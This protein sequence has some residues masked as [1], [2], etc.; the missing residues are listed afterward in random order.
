MEQ[1]RTLSNRLTTKYLLIVRNEEN[2]AEKST[3]SFTYSK[4]I[5][6]LV[7]SFFAFFGLS[8]YL[9]TSL[10]EAW[11]DPRFAELKAT[12]EVMELAT[13]VDSLQL[14]VRKKDDFISNIKTIMSGEDA[15]YTDV[16]NSG[17]IESSEITEIVESRVINPIDSQF[18]EEF[19]KGGLEFQLTDNR[20]SEELQDFFLFKPVDGIVSEHFDP[21]IDHL[22]IDI[23][24]KQDE[25]VKSVADGTVIFASWTQD[26]GYVMAIQHRGNLISMY[27][28]N[29]DLL[30]N[31]GNFVTAGE[32]VSIIGNTG[33][34]TSGPHLHF[35]LWY[36]GNPINPEELIRF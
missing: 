35:E 8:F 4:I 19:E 26:S 11:F 29:S 12:K 24:A 2:F 25:P 18:R 22:A 3:Y 9:S 33:E 21:Q 20:L 28:H 17:T 6:V 14:E 32:V 16:D 13:R 31:V 36:N 1:K 15:Q 10:L 5:L 30:K 7:L 27:K 34:L 23:V